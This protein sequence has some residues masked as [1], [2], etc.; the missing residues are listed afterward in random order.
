MNK[1]LIHTALLVAT[2]LLLALAFAG[3]LLALQA[4]LDEASFL[5][6]VLRAELPTATPTATPTLEP[7]ATAT[8]EPTATSTTIPTAT[9]TPSPTATNT[10]V[11]TATATSTPQPPGGCSTCSANVY[12]CSDFGSQAAAQAC[13]DYCMQRVGYDVHELDSDGDGEACESLPITGLGGW[14][15]RWP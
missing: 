3:G 2:T 11:P 4:E 7:T 10:T 13:H 9:A 15:L 8:L 14:S 6:V 5:P 1:N 12:N